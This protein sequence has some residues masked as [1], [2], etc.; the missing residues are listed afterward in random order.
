M[1]G[2]AG[3]GAPGPEIGLAAASPDDRAY[4]F[5]MMRRICEPVI[6]NLAAQDAS[7]AHASR[8]SGGPENQPRRDFAHLEAFGRTVAGVA[9]WIELPEKPREEAVLGSEGS[10]ISCVADWTMRRTRHRPMH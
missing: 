2:P 6:E 8:V 4:W 1:A 7:R 3:I 10:A 5:V 9:P